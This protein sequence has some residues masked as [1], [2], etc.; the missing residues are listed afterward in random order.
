MGPWLSL[1]EPLKQPAALLFADTGS[2]ILHRPYEIQCILRRQISHHGIIDLAAETRF[3]VGSVQTTCN[4]SCASH[5]SELE[6]KASSGIMRH[7]NAYS[8]DLD[9]ICEEVDELDR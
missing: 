7:A 5:A 8:A 1:L 2:R 3:L 9:S 6:A 4:S